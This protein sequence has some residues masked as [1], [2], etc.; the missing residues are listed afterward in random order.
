M[1][2]A[3]AAPILRS[4]RSFQWYWNSSVDPWSEEQWTKY[5]DIENEIIEDALNANKEE[6]D[7]DRNYVISLKDQL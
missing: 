3:S 6:V 5:T 1:S 7:I 2:T 4:P